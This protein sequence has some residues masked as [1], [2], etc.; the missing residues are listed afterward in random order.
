MISMKILI[1]SN[2]R[3]FHESFFNGNNIEPR[4]KPIKQNEQPYGCSLFLGD[5]Q[6]S[7]GITL[8]SSYFTCWFQFDSDLSYKP[9]AWSIAQRSR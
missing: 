8:S 6:G 1:D 3:N 9:A 4:P 2:L 7:K 5:C